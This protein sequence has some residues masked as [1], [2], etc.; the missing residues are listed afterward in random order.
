MIRI[1]FFGTPDFAV[2]CLKEL[3]AAEGIKVAAVVSAPDKPG[4]R[5]R[6]LQASPVSA[7]ARDRGLLLLQPERLRDE[8]FIATLQ[9][10]N[11]DL[12]A[13][14]AFRMLPEVVWSMPRFGSLNIHGSLLPDLRGAAPIQWSIALG[15]RLTGLTAFSLNNAIDEGPIL[16]QTEVEIGPNETFSS[17]YDRMAAQG[18][19]LALSVLQEMDSKVHPIIAQNREEMHRSAPKLG[20]EFAKLESLATAKMVHD[21]IRACDS[22]PGASLPSPL[23]SAERFKLFSSYWHSLGPASIPVD[24]HYIIDNEGIKIIDA[25]GYADILEVQWPGKRRM[26][27]SEFLRGSLLRGSFTLNGQKFN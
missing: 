1:V 18:S 21:R 5:G 7:M 27:T 19:Q 26:Q 11:A 15:D 6:Q 24:I 12:F 4:R 23:N 14:V 9:S 3:L 22:V 10:L 20:P 13:V 16:A 17:L 8:D 2:T 25:E